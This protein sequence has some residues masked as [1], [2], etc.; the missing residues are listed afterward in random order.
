MYIVDVVN[1]GWYYILMD[2]LIKCMLFVSVRFFLNN[3]ISWVVDMFIIVCYGFIIRFY[4][5][6]LND[7]SIRL[8]FY[9]Y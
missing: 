3:G 1:K 8:L 6:L 2:E 5:I 4:V 9:I 7:M